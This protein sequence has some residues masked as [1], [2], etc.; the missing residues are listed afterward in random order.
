MAYLQGSAGRPRRPSSKRDVL[1]LPLATGVGGA[2]LG[3]VEVTA[4]VARVVRRRLAGRP[5]RTPH[6]ASATALAAGRTGVRPGVEELDVVGDDQ[7]LAPL[8]AVL[9][10]PLVHP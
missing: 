10:G 3:I 1:F 5:P 2:R 6:R 4:A 7:Q 9:P 8:L